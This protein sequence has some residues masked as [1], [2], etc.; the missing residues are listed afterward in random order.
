MARKSFFLAL[1]FLIAFTSVFKV[2]RPRA[3]SFAGKRLAVES[4]SNW[5]CPLGT[6]RGTH[7]RHQLR[8]VLSTS[9]SQATIMFALDCGG[10]KMLAALSPVLRGQASAPSST[11]C[12]LQVKLQV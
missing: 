1:A 4:D 3:E 5:H 6:L 10:A 2:E 11:L 7:H 8:P 9:K 12:N